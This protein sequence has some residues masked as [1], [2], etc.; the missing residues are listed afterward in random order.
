MSE[1]TKDR[2]QKRR[3]REAHCGDVSSMSVV[4]HFSAVRAMVLNT[5]I[6]KTTRS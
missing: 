3:R 5:Y 1:H 4:G 6:K 2:W